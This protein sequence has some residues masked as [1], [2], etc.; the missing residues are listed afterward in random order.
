MRFHRRPAYPVS[1]FAVITLAVIAL[2]TAFLLWDLR[3]RELEH[4]R[5]ETVGIT[6]IFL[7]QTERN[8]ESADLVLKGVQDRLQ[9]SLG[10]QFPLDGLAIH[11]LLGTRVLEMRQL[12]ALYLVDPDGWIVNSSLEPAVGRISVAGSNYFKAFAGGADAGLFIDKP[13]RNAAARSWTLY[14]ARK[15]SGPDGKLRGVVVGAIDTAHFEDIYKFLKLTY[16][17]PVSLYLADGTL[18]ASVPHRENMIGERAPEFG[19]ESLPPRGQDLRFA[20]HLKGDGSREAFTLGRVPK[21]PLLVSVTND[22]DE[23]LA[24][25]RETAVPIVLV[26][27][28]VSMFI[29]AAAAFLIRELTREQNLARALGEANDRYYQTVD[30]VMDAIVA[31]D[32]YQNIALFNRA[33]ERMFGRAAQ[34]VMGQPVTLLMPPHLARAHQ[35]HVRGFMASGTGSRTMAPMLEITGLRADGSQFPVESTISQTL[36]VLPHQ[37]ER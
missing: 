22:E 29:I 6:R 20:S 23:A 32:Q 12:D 27:T 28:I 4:A 16:V 14:L 37:H 8:F 11:L 9:T 26:A 10:S 33:A 31:I 18:I 7:E 5:L 15:I 2:S 24:S 19:P 1:L 30:S 17:R 3:K 34:E 36:I 25:W 35:G 13:V 21:Y